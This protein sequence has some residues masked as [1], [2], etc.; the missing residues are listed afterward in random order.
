MFNINKKETSRAEELTRERHRG[1][2]GTGCRL[3]KSRNRKTWGQPG[4][5][6]IRNIKFLFQGIYLRHIFSKHINMLQIHLIVVEI[7]MGTEA[8]W[9]TD[10]CQITF[11]ILFCMKHA[12]CLLLFIFTFIFHSI[13]LLKYQC[14][15]K[16]K[17]NPKYESVLYLITVT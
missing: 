9:T 7:V 3:C 15:H 16:K 5:T 11:N 12:F 14:K 6:N 17:K 10:M 2:M 8:C 13:N 1:I 4:S